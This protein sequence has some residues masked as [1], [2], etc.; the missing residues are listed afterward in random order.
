MSAS[1]NATLNLNEYADMQQVPVLQENALVSVLPLKMQ[2]QAALSAL[3]VLV[4]LVSLLR[5]F[6]L[7]IRFRPLY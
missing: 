1:M 5:S 7:V 2:L 6:A 3:V 4:L